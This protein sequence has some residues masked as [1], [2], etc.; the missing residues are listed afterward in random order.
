MIIKRLKLINWRNYETEEVFWDESVNLIHGANAQGKTNLIE[1]ISYL[2]LASSF[3]GAADIDL[4]NKEK[5][6]FYLE[7]D[8]VSDIEGKIAISAA[9]DK[10][11]RRK[12]QINKEPKQRLI[13]IIGIFHTV[14]FSPDDI[15]LVKG[16]A[17]NRRRWLNRQ[18][19][20]LNPAYCR[21]LLTYN[22][23]LKQRNACL[24]D[25]AQQKNAEEAKEQLSIW[26]AQ[27]LDAGAHITLTR[28][29][30]I[31]K[32]TEIAADIHAGL[33]AGEKLQLN[34]ESAIFGKEKV[35]DLGEIAERFAKELLRQKQRELLRGRTLVGPHLDDVQ[36][37]L[38]KQAARDFASQGQQRTLAVSIK[39]SELELAFRQKKEYPVLLLDDVLSEL[40]ETRRKKILSLPEKAQTFITAAG[41]DIELP[42][43]KKWLVQAADGIGHIKG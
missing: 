17:A 11:K 23:I 18:I 2:G 22:N 42:R 5:E 36:I 38:D 12:W 39:L 10:N 29:E 6:H 1:A 20:Q 3:R 19:S 27:L 8:I 13:D 24:K 25:W 33:S 4:I 9:M 31:G 16:A 40:D 26:D 28:A 34:Y 37:V 21:L 32:L 41:K 15:Y 30:I 14:V 35:R 7:A 43:G